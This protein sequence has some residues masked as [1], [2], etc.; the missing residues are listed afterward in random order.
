MKARVWMA[1]ALVGGMCQYAIAHAGEE[2]E[3]IDAGP[4]NLHALARAWPIGPFSWAGL[5]ILLAWYAVGVTSVWRA[6]GPDHGIRRW[7]V[8][9]FAAGWLTLFVALVSPLHT[10]GSMLFSVHMTQHELLMLVAAPLLVL[11]KPMLHALPRGIAHAAGWLSNRPLWRTVWAGL[12]HPMT[13]W[14]IHAAVLWAWH[15][16]PLFDAVERSELAHAL[17]HMSFLGSAILFWWSLIHARRDAAAYG[18][19]V[20]YVF[21]TALHSGML[22]A[23]LTFARTAWYPV[24]AGRT[25]AWGLT[26]IEDQQLGGLI[27][28]IPACAVYIVAGLLMFAGWLQASDRSAR[29]RPA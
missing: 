19:A 18:A 10:W 20:L 17:Q 29:S 4:R 21:T 22:G 25:E 28:W 24:Y 23:L 14:L 8:A 1:L 5:T 16:P 7:E 6:A 2:H 13:A 11:S 27:M 26:A 12:S 9:A 15:A 3:S